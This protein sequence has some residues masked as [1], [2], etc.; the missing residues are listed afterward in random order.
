[1]VGRQRSKPVI[2][3][4]VERQTRKSIYVLVKNKTQKEVLQAVRRAH[5]R[6][7]G[8]FTQVFKSI[9]A[10]NGSE[11]LD[12]KGLQKAAKCDE[13]YYAHPFSSWERGSNEN[14]K[15][16]LRRF[17]P[18]GTDFSTLKPRD[19]KRIEDWV[20]NYP[21]KKYTPPIDGR[22]RFSEAFLCMYC[23]LHDAFAPHPLGRP[24][25]FEGRHTS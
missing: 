18:K 15:R 2:L 24:I 9:T 12:S 14:G 10:D 4:L 11:F 16:I 22:S 7:K 19:L 3:T 1:M 6:V 5:R 23:F 21:R 25:V 17:L 20:N 13:V 8:D